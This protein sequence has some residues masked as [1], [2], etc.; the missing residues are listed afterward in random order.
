MSGQ[1]RINVRAVIQKNNSIL[2]CSLVDKRYFFLPGG[3]VEFGEGAIVALKRELQEE[4]GVKP[5]SANFIGAVEN[6]FE[7]EGKPSH[8]LNLVFAAQIDNT[9][10][11][12]QEVHIAFSWMSGDRLE[13]ENVLPKQMVTAVLRWIKNGKVFWVGLD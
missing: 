2:L 1:T 11:V 7:Q 4:L 5:L 13:Q 12:S 10:I 6:L 9:N 8:E 3:G